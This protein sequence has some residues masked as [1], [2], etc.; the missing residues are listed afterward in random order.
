M[1]RDGIPLLIAVIVVLAVVGATVAFGSTGSLPTS[2][3]EVPGGSPQ[4]GLDAIQRF[5]CG[6]CH[7]IPG[8]EGA[9]GLVGPPLIKWADRKTIAGELPNET[10]QLIRWIQDPQEVEPGTDMPDLGVSEQ[11][12]RDIAAYLDTLH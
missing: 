4:R 9:D 3:V 6:S 5:G 11:A 2:V 8:V 12:A 7:I 1:K 10:A